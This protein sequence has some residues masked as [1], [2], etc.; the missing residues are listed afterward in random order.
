MQLKLVMTFGGNLGRNFLSGSILKWHKAAGEEV[1]YG[2]DLFDLRVEE[3]AM[4][5]S[6]L[7]QMRT[8]TGAFRGW[9]DHKSWVEDAGVRTMTR[10]DITADETM[11]SRRASVGVRVRASD[12]GFL[13][14]VHTK[15]GERCR[16][17]D[18]VAL[19]TTAPDEVVEEA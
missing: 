18:L 12:G 8:P 7:E 3:V 19:L 17:G 2:D 10:K 16:A 14:K 13:R 9:T 5:R 11:M 6:R 1:R 4:Y 15:E